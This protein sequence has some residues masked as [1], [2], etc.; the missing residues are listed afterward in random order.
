M[1]FNLEQPGFASAQGTDPPEVPAHDVSLHPLAA[2][3]P[4]MPSYGDS[5]RCS[6]PLPWEE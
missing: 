3:S 5:T 2:S 1:S 4:S 6:C